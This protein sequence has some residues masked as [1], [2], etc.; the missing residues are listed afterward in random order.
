M[1][2][3]SKVQSPKCKVQSAKSKVQSPKSK[4]QSPKSWG[5]GFKKFFC[6]LCSL[7]AVTCTLF[8]VTFLSAC[9]RKT[10]VR[11]PE[12]VAPESVD[13]LTLAVEGKGIKLL[14]GRPQKYVDGSDMEDLAGFV[15]L[16]ATQNDQ[17]EA[18]SFTQVATVTVDDRDRFR[19]AKKFSYTDEQ[20]TAG[21]LY[22]YRVQVFTLDGYYSSPSNTVELVWKG[23]P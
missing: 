14:W 10:P 16:R 8:S 9:G 15:V 13:D 17:G 5:R 3:K 19:K 22:R 12:L 7:F 23:G 21:T 2:S 4:V 20:L 11:P 6:V 1:G 18:D